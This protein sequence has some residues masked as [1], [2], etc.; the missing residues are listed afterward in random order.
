MKALAYFAPLFAP[1]WK[2][3]A[4]A[5]VLS[6]ITIAA[7]TA[8]LGV[9]GWFLTA[10]ALTGAGISFNLFAPSAAVRGFSLIRIVSRYFEKLIGHNATLSL[11]SD[12][13]RWLF[14]AL[15]PRLPLPGRSL[16]HGD[17][18]SRLT[19]D[20]DN[21][22]QLFLLAIGPMIAAIILGS[23][24]T[25]VL[26]HFLSAAAV[27]YGVA[28][29]VALFVIP[30]IL[31]AA[32]KKRGQNLVE[33]AAALRTHVLDAVAG[34]D[35]I[36]LFG[37]QQQTALRFE[38]TASELASL[39]KKQSLATSIAGASVQA[40]TGLAL[41][42]ILFTGLRTLELDAI[43][44]ALLAG[45]VFAVMGSF[46]A[47]NVIIRSVGRFGQAAA[48]AER[49][50]AVATMPPAI[51]EAARP[52]A[53]PEGNDIHFENVTFGYGASRPILEN[54]PLSL[55]AGEHVAISGPSGSGKSTLLALLLRL[56]DPQKGSITI[57]RTDTRDVALADL[58]A[59]VALL[60]QD[61][62]V[63][64]DTVRNNL[65]IA[66]P[67]ATDAELWS[68]LRT[69]RLE[70][71]IRALPLGLDTMIGETGA[72]LSAGQARRLCLARTLLSPAGIVALDEPTAGLD[73]QTELEFL[74]DIPAALAGRTVL[75]VSHAQI[76]ADLPLRRF[77]LAH[78]ELEEQSS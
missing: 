75:L 3:L 52:I 24:I 45:L 35:D 39:R 66:Q 47:T 49:L 63:F 11:L 21:L 57:A 54:I 73:R 61:S 50:K 65:L 30:V 4:L 32:T 41:I 74:S 70:Q 46:E 20:V 43:T 9:S 42:A 14:A 67:Q 51:R 23:I 68:A 27:I 55:A 6:L 48:S 78:G 10:T 25:G 37:Q 8:L 22:D 77:I 44:G 19:A 2:R 7:G 72:T 31:I 59:R 62:P 18:V 69:A 64:F 17:L 76:P 5:L 13:R 60:S 58:H 71:T 16:R 12:I 56:A 36:I 33:T 29:S 26:A 1:H 53:L 28:I 38:K 34:H 15:F 40:L